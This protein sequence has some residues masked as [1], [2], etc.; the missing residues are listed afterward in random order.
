MCV[1]VCVCVLERQTETEAERWERDGIQDFSFRY[2]KLEIFVRHLCHD[3]NQILDYVT[4]RR[5]WNRN[6]NL[7]VI[8]IMI[9]R[10]VM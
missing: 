5:D 2:V 1:C 6:R 7:A 10:K 3:I 4:Q 9:V 8:G